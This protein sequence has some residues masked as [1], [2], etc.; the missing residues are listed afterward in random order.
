MRIFNGKRAAEKILLRLKEKILKD[1]IIPVL[2]VISVGEDPAS[3]LFIRN[4]KQ[5]A[6]RIGI[7]VNHYNRFKETVSEEE[8]IQKIKELDNDLAVNGIIVQLPLPKKLNAKKIVGGISPHKDVDGFRKGTHFSSPLISGILTAL[9]DSTKKPKG[10]K[11]I[12]LVN[13][14]FFGRVLK[15]S[16]KKEAIKINYLKNKKSPAVKTADIV[17]TVCGCPNLIKGDMIKKGAIL[18]DGGITVLK[19]KKVVGDVDKKSV[20][21]KAR[22]LTPV[23]G[24][25][26]PLTVA[27]LLKNVYLA[28]MAERTKFSS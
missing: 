8:I 27:F 17:I 10:K 20:A 24:G 19:N 22:F 28:K 11:I 6:K 13:S 14:D 5:A 23:P 18:I 9:K 15:S 16:L 4:K 12:A 25:L 26:G 2:S 7:K 3:K 21:N 1:K